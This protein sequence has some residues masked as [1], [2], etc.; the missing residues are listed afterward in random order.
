METRDDG[1]A[2]PPPD[3]EAALALRDLREDA[4]EVRHG[5]RVARRAAPLDVVAVPAEGV[6]AGRGERSRTMT[7]AR[8]VQ[9]VSR[10]ASLLCLALVLFVA[11]GIWG[12]HVGRQE[13]LAV[14][15]LPSQLAGLC[16]RSGWVYPCS[17]PDCVKK[18]ARDSLSIGTQEKP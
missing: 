18:S 12:R 6:E 7:A 9:L 13:I 10:V 1:V 3:L 17:A 11:G 15:T 14:T 4:R 16:G 8:V 2:A 5:L